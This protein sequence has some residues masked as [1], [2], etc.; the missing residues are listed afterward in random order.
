MITSSNLSLYIHIPWCVKKCPYCDFNSHKASS[1]IPE[2]EY[3]AALQKNLLQA[4][5]L[6]K[7]RSIGTI[8]FG[9]G[10]PSLFSATSINKIL[11]NSK[12]LLAFNNN[13]EITLEANPGT[14]ERESFLAYKQAGINR[15]SLGAQSFNDLHLKKLGRIHSSDETNTALIE[16]QKSGINNFNIDIMYGLPQQDLAAA[17]QDLTTALSYNPK[18]FSWYNL[19]IEPN[20]LF[21]NKPPELPNDDL[22]WD[23]QQTGLE[24]LAE[25][26]LEQYEVSAFSRSNQQ[27]QHNLNYWQFGDYLGI[28][29]GAHSKITNSNDNSITRI[30]NHKHPKAYLDL[31]NNF[32]NGTEIITENNLAFEFMLNALRLTNGFALDL[33][34]KTTGLALSSIQDKL[35]K[36]Q[37]NGLISIHNNKLETTPLGKRFLNDLVGIWL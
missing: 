17:M 5:P 8:F 33:F 37:D 14:I 29:A 36:S 21:H 31:H 20:T 32:I 22:I 15:I 35:Q 7:N 25:H 4:L 19:T 11:T 27:S 30:W 23:M 13:I 10:T 28:G 9:G 34:T 2:Q 26:G 16:L 3:I 6:I 1:S 12:E 24:I 18:H